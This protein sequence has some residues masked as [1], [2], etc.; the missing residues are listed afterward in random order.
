MSID[1]LIHWV[2]VPFWE[3]S[4][5][6]FWIGPVRLWN[7][8]VTLSPISFPLFHTFT[9]CETNKNSLYHFV[10][11]ATCIMH[12][13]RPRVSGVSNVIKRVTHDLRVGPPGR[14]WFTLIVTQENTRRLAGRIGSTGVSMRGWGH[15]GE[16]WRGKLSLTGEKW[17]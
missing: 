2:S 7:V 14:L 4:H 8:F 11:Y 6:L 3:I 16:K 5:C 10:V 12:T 9:M 15:N 13:D 17:I 1:F